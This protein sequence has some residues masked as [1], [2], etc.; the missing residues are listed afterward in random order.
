MKINPKEQENELSKRFNCADCTVKLMDVKLLTPKHWRVIITQQDVLA[1][2]IAME[3]KAAAISLPIMDKKELNTE[4][5]KNKPATKK[6]KAYLLVNRKRDRH[7]NSK[8]EMI[9][10]DDDEIYKRDTFNLSQ[11]ENIFDKLDSLTE[12]QI[13]CFNLTQADDSEMKKIYTKRIDEFLLIEKFKQTND[14][15]K[16]VDGKPFKIFLL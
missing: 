14:E 6:K 5:S 1:V 3:K 2:K 11:T 16:T 15:N 7:N 13:T 8:I 12:E 4:T 10:D 9:D